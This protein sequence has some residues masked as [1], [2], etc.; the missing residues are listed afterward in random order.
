MADNTNT[1]EKEKIDFAAIEKKWQKK[2]EEAKVFEANPDKRKK[3][4][5]N[6]PYPYINGHLHF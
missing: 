6:F 5:I 2:W 4:F 3:Y 1:T